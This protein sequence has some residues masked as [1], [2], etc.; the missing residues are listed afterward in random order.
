MIRILNV[1]STEEDEL[2]TLTS[3]AAVCDEGSYLHTLLSEELVTWVSK[4]IKAGVPPDVMTNWSETLKE[5]QKEASKALELSV[6][7]VESQNEI[8]RLEMLLT[9][10]R[11][12]LQA[13]IAEWKQKYEVQ[14]AQGAHWSALS[15][16]TASIYKRKLEE[17]DSSLTQMTKK[18]NQSLVELQT[19]RQIT[20]NQHTEIL[21][22]KAEVYD[23][24]HR[25]ED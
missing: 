1:R 18:W 6:Q 9:Q 12:D 7:V 10:T 19:L 16:R 20:N 11:N 14:G 21:L 25:R 5:G 24:T 22:L 3:M 13:E 15:D 23:L 4:M 2:E 8:T 17:K